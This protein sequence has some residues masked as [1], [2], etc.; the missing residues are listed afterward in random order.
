MAGLREGVLRMRDAARARREVADLEAEN[1]KLRLQ[2]ERL[3]AAMR[4]CLTCEY[5]VAALDDG[6]PAD[7]AA[8]SIPGIRDQ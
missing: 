8:S 1:A 6:H 5:R 3:R 2:N 4:R 7:D